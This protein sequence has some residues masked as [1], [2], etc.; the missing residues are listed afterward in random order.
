MKATFLGSRLCKIGGVLE[1]C[2]QNTWL[3]LLSPAL[4]LNNLVQSKRY[5]AVAYSW[6]STFRWEAIH[7]PYTVPLPKNLL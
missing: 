4:F 7:D 6:H 1:N 2:Q 3:N 5:I